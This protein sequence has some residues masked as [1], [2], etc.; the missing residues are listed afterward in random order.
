MYDDAGKQGL[1][2]QIDEDDGGRKAML[3]SQQMQI[4]RSANLRAGG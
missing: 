2:K 1:K 3:S 4:N